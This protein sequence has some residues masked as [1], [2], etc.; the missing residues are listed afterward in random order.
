MSDNK[1]ETQGPRPSNSTTSASVN[2]E[3]NGASHGGASQHGDVVT[4]RITMEAWRERDA[5]IE[6]ARGRQASRTR[7]APA[8]K[9]RNPRK[10]LEFQEDIIRT[11]QSHKGMHV[12][13]TGIPTVYAGQCPAD[14]SKAHWVFVTKAH[15]DIIATCAQ[16]C[17]HIEAKVTQKSTWDW[18]VR[19]KGHQS[20]NLRGIIADGMFAGVLVR[21]APERGAHR[22]FLVPWDIEDVEG[23]ED[24]RWDDLRDI[25]LELGRLDQWP[26]R[27]AAWYA[28]RRGA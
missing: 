3:R 6:A 7:D 26:S 25:G 14:K 21:Y 20:Q 22:H 23:L 18:D 13:Y 1:S 11:G 19:L 5:R 28:Q 17:A 8:S 16:W 4:P 15:V 27:I 10:G 9:S 24:A 2:A 12:V